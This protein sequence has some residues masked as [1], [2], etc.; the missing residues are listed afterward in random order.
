VSVIPHTDY[1]L[2]IFFNYRNSMFNAK[3]ISLRNSEADQIPFWTLKRNNAA[4]FDHML[5]Y[6]VR[7]MRGYEVV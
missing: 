1:A 6:N 5:K 3:V 2:S 4:M 7:N